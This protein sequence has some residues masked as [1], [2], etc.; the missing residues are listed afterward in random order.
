LIKLFSG[1]LYIPTLSTIDFSSIVFFTTPASIYR[2]FELWEDRKKLRH[3]ADQHAGLLQSYL[4]CSIRLN[5]S[6][7]NILSKKGDGSI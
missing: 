6:D 3:I 5:F 2:L 4:M 1:K 7:V